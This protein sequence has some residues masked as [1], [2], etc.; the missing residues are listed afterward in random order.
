MEKQTS[1]KF[2]KKELERLNCKPEDI[3]LILEYQMRLPILTEN[4][5]VEGFCVDARTLWEQLGVGRHFGTWIVNNLKFFTENSDYI[6]LVSPQIIK[7]LKGKKGQ[8]CGFAGS[9]GRSPKEYALTINTAK[10]IA[11]FTGAAPQAS[12]Q[13]QE[14]THL[15]RR[16]FIT[17]EHIVHDNKNWKSIRQPERDNYS[18]LCEAVTQNIKQATGGI[19]DKYDFAREADILNKICTGSRAIDIK[20]YFGTGINELTRDSLNAD[21]NAKLSFLQNQ[22]I[23][24]LKTGMNFEDRIITL[25]SFFN[26]M[27]PNAQKL[28]NGSHKDLIKLQNDLIIYKDMSVAK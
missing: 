16:Y 23:I 25:I 14:V 20:A 18:V 5:D 9:V 12:K 26:A 19:A 2:T 11:M 3:S 1:N 24:L 28:I 17:M 6:T 27:Y 21:Y 15:V 13:L 7:P 22:D 4:Q 10:E 8:P